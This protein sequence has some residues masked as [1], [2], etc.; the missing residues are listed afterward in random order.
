M[1][2]DR[3]TKMKLPDNAKHGEGGWPMGWVVPASHA[4]LIEPQL[5]LNQNA[6]PKRKS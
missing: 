1:K 3:T 6:A 4:M 2:N 5:S